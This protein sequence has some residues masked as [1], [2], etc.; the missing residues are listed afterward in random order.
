MKKNSLKEIFTKDNKY[1]SFILLVLS[2]IGLILGLLLTL[3]ILKLDE[4]FKMDP[5]FLGGLL[6]VVSVFSGILSVNK[7]NKQIK[8]NR[9]PKPLLYNIIKD[10]CD[11]KDEKI[12][13]MFSD[14]G[15]P[16]INEGDYPI[17]YFGHNKK[18]NMFIKKDNIE[19]CVEIDLKYIEMELCLSDE[20][21]MQV[22]DEF[23][24]YE[25]DL[26]SKKIEIDL[27]TGFDTLINHI[28]LFYEEKEMLLLERYEKYKK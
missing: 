8:Y 9:T 23:Y 22:S 6:I 11:N 17:F 4:E 20:L 25:G 7:I 18:Y 19:I 5:M 10:A 28:N 3:N 27:N 15:Y 12:V 16:L 24:E 13:K 21:D 2:I 1:E 26:F 14:S